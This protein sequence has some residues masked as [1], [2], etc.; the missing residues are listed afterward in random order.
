MY[1]KYE[2]KSIRRSKAAQTAR[3]RVRRRCN[4]ANINTMHG[5][6]EVNAKITD[7]KTSVLST[8]REGT[9]ATP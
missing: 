6:S 9:D 1:R 5:W 8:S 7:D 2:L 4:D 3:I